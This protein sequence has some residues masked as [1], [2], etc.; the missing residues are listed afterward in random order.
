MFI[1][2]ACFIFILSS[3]L[4]V[5][6]AFHRKNA[7]LIYWNK[8]LEMLFIHHNNLKFRLK[9]KKNRTVLWH[10]VDDKLAFS[11]FSSIF[12]FDLFLN[13]VLCFQCRVSL[14]SVGILR[15]RFYWLWTQSNQWSHFTKEACHNRFSFFIILSIFFVIIINRK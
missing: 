7:L 5:G 15:T 6:Y 10:F 14:K 3:L 13:G 9:K 8:C 4:L 12:F 1:P 11:M 2:P